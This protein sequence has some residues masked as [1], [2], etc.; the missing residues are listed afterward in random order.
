MGNSLRLLIIDDNKEILAALS[1]FF[2]KKYDVVSANNGLD[3]M[4]LLEAEKEGFDLIITDIVMPYISGAG[5]IS[6]VKEKH[7]NIPVIAITGWGKSLESLAIEAHADLVIEKPFDLSE[8]DKII[9]ELI[10]H[11]KD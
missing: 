5:V 10:P 1:D 7:P 4:K 2:S 8:L 6:A 3:G 9:T 11:N